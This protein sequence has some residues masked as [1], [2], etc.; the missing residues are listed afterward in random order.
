[1][2]P[3][4]LSVYLHV[5]NSPLKVYQIQY[6]L[7][8]LKAM[9]EEVYTHRPT[10]SHSESPTEQKSGGSGVVD[11]ETYSHVIRL[12]VKDV[13]DRS[14][15]QPPLELSQLSSDSE[16]RVQIPCSLYSLGVQE[17]DDGVTPRPQLSFGEC[18]RG[19]I[20][21]GVIFS[22]GDQSFETSGGNSSTHSTQ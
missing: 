21:E 17:G 9:L 11:L 2:E 1:M 20:S 4:S 5:H 3:L 19:V 7:Q 16:V 18:V 14:N 22:A 6:N 12:W 8:L 13:R 15:Q 10:L